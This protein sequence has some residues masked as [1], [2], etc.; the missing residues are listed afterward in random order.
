MTLLCVEAGSYVGNIPF[1]CTSLYPSAI[2]LTS[3]PCSNGSHSI[4]PGATTHIVLFEY[5]PSTSFAERS[6]IATAFIASACGSTV[7]PQY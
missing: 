5:T 4:T 6:E 1:T 7:H 2:P 3:W